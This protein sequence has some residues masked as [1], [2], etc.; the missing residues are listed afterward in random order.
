MGRGARISSMNSAKSSC[1]DGSWT[2][3]SLNNKLDDIAVDLNNAI[4]ADSLSVYSSTFSSL[5]DTDPSSDSYIS[6]ACS[7]ISTEIQKCEEKDEEERREAERRRQEELDRLAEAA[8]ALLH[9]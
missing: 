7:S 6:S 3:S 2:V 9:L 1:V 5:K 8:A 4:K